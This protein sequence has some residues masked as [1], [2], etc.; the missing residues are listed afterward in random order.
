MFNS[1]KW[2]RLPRDACNSSRNETIYR[3]L[4]WKGAV[5]EEWT[6]MRYLHTTMS[7]IE[8]SRLHTADGKQAGS[9]SHLATIKITLRLSE[10]IQY[11]AF[12]RF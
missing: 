12:N 3:T 9:T 6:K 11:I 10:R 2:L 4:L 7:V 1:P 5:C 8:I